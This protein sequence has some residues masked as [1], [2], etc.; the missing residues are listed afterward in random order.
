ML[1]H[2]PQVYTAKLSAAKKSICHCDLISTLL[3]L[4]CPSAEVQF[5][6]VLLNCTLIVH[7]CSVFTQKCNKTCRKTG[8]VLFHKNLSIV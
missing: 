5:I 4:H 6:M 1:G 2:P 7:I 8:I 3:Q